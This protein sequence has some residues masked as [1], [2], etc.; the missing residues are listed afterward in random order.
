MTMAILSLFLA[1]ALT[2]AGN[3][4]PPI[5]VPWDSVSTRDNQAHLRPTAPSLLHWMQ[6][7]DT[8]MLPRRESTQNVYHDL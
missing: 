8:S 3:P 5:A 4:S 2:S 7:V 6:D 1:I